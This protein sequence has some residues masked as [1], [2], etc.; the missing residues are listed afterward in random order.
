MGETVA[1]PAPPDTLPER[2]R[3]V[4]SSQNLDAAYGFVIEANVAE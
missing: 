2:G 4:F 1:I 3:F